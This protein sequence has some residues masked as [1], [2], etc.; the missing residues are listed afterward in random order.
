M[1]TQK[2]RKEPE[3]TRAIATRTQLISAAKALIVRA[4][5]HAC[6]STSDIA[7]EAG[8]AIGTVYRYFS[9]AEDLLLEAFDSTHDQVVGQWFGG[10]P[11]LRGLSPLDQATAFLETYIACAE[12]DPAYVPLLRTARQLRSVSD[13]MSINIDTPDSLSAFAAIFDITPS[14]PNLSGLRLLKFVTQQLTAL[15]LLADKA[16]QDAIGTEIISYTENALTNLQRT[17]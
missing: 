12:Q 14:D 15:Y 6:P 11:S 9:K 7:E 13:E 5:G 10:L 4:G 1:M 16:N 17:E 8:V 2:R 3:Q